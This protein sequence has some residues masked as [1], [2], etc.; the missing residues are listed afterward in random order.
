MVGGPLN[1]L[2]SRSRTTGPWPSLNVALTPD[3]AFDPDFYRDHLLCRRA[4]NNGLVLGSVIPGTTE[5]VT[6]FSGASDEPGQPDQSGLLDTTGTARRRRART[7]ASSM[8]ATA[9]GRTRRGTT[10]GR[11]SPAR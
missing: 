3:G 11:T 1:D 10:T 8:A 5:V 7:T 6:D 4:D 2:A 9:S